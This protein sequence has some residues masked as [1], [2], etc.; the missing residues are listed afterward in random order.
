MMQDVMQGAYQAVF[1]TPEMLMGKKRWGQMLLN[2]L[3]KS[4]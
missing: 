1:F 3:F 4:S 2:D